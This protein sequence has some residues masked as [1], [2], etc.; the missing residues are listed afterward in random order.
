MG[1]SLD[2]SFTSHY[3]VTTLTSSIILNYDLIRT[4]FTPISSQAAPL[5]FH[6]STSSQSDAGLER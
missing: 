1:I 4:E 3:V 6:H 5:S 2:P